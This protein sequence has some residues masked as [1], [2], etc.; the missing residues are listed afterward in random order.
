MID[1]K[2]LTRSDQQIWDDYVNTST[3]TTPYHRFA[4]GKA[5][6]RSYGF[7]TLYVGAFH[8]NKLIGIMPLIRMGMPFRQKSLVSLPYCDGAGAVADTQEAL[9]A[10]IAFA[11]N[12]LTKGTQ[13]PV[14]LRHA[15]TT[16]VEPETLVDGQKVRML[17]SLAASPDEQMA[18]FKSKLRS[19][20][21]KAEKNGLTSTVIVYNDTDSF[22]QHM[23]EFYAVIAGNMRLLG[24]PVHSKAWFM[25][26]LREYADNAYMVLVYKEKIVVG[27]GIV[28][29]N[30]N[31]ASIPWASTNAEYNRLAPN[32]L[33]YWAVLNE[34]ITKGA[35]VFDFGRSTVNE[36]TYNFKKQWGSQ[37]APLHW[38]TYEGGNLVEVLDIGKSKARDLVESIWKQLPLWLVNY[39]GPKVRKFVSL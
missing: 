18:N 28:L 8:E 33:L 39:V 4:W 26:V 21:R 7:E 20:I 15:D 10:L 37:P 34:A 32:M 14:E 38:A 11:T 5:V 1:V 9:K 2:Q 17:L 13:E 36:G 24:S 16:T 35:Q 22:A 29:Q 31:T 19:Q 30:N 12:D 6:E 3:K 23:D 25:S 27:G